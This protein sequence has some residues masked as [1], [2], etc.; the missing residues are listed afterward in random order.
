MKYDWWPGMA[1]IDIGIFINF[2]GLFTGF[3]PKKIL[4]DFEI[5]LCNAPFHWLYFC[6][7]DHKKFDR[8]H[9]KSN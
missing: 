5:L 9:Y 6:E 4:I 7:N 1:S 3:L 2:F 8:M